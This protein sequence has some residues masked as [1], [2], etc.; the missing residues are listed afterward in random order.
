ML[1]LNSATDDDLAPKPAPEDIAS[2]LTKLND[3]QREAVEYGTQASNA[4]DPAGALL[5]IAGAGSGKTNVLA[6][7]V[8]NLIVNR[9]DPCRIILVLRVLSPLPV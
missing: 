1:T 7:R 3:V 2:Y 9:V 8:A 6:Y 5:V 4:S